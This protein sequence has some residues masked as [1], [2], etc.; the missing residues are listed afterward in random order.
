MV[1]MLVENTLATLTN[2]FD[3]DPTQSSQNGIIR[4]GSLFKCLPRIR[5]DSIKPSNGDCHQ[6]DLAAKQFSSDGSQDSGYFGKVETQK[7]RSTVVQLSE[8]D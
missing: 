7:H 8:T 1:L 5:C 6:K 4:I 3:S 2:T